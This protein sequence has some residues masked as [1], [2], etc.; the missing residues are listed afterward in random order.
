[1]T[2]RSDATTIGFMLNARLAD[3]VGVIFDLDGTLIDTLDDIADSLNLVL[4]ESG[5][6]R[7]SRAHVRS[8]IGEGLTSLICRASGV[9]DPDELARLVARYR[10]IYSERMFLN[11]RPYPGIASL[12]DALSE[13]RIPMCILSNKSHE[14]T[15]PMCAQL[16]SRWSFVRVVGA[17][18]EATRKPDPTNALEMAEVM[19]LD[20]WEVWFVGDSNV[21]VQTGQNA[22]MRTI[23]VTWGLRDRQELIEAKPNALVDEPMQILHNVLGG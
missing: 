4:E 20:P 6:V 22:G 19:G 15:V 23:A 18:D 1:M 9:D 21:D 17:T 7:L 10:T 2:A 8:I 14:F 11:T 5:R 16:L 12:L 3:P 13:R